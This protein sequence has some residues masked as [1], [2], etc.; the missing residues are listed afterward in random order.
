MKSTKSTFK[1]LKSSWGICITIGG[2]SEK[3]DGDSNELEILTL[4]QNL[5][6]EEIAFLKNGFNYFF[7]LVNFD[8]KYKISI[9]E[10]SFSDCDCQIEGL[11][12][13]MILWL[14]EH[15]EVD[16]LDFKCNFNQVL[17]RYEFTDLKRLIENSRL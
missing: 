14:S 8:F 7:S 12:Y 2:T 10:L 17:N 9:D 6:D 1:L 16:M 11:F 5:M 15:F 4:S 13:A 3:I